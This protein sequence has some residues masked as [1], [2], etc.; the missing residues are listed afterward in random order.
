MLRFLKLENTRAEVNREAVLFVPF[1]LILRLKVSAAAPGRSARQTRTILP[2]FMMLSG[3]SA[4]LIVR[5]TVTA[6]PCSAGR[7]SS[8]P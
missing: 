3:S 8:F 2:G 4:C 6:S 7:N 5:I 1:F